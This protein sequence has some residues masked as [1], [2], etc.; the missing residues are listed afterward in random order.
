MVRLFAI[1]VFYKGLKPIQKKASYELSSFGYF[2]RS[3]VREFMA[4]TSDVLVERTSPGQRQ[5]VREQEYRCHV[6]VRSD[7][8]AC[9]AIADMDYPVRVAF[10]LM[11]KVLELYSSDFPR[12]SWEQPP[13]DLSYPPLDDFLKKYQDPKEADS[14]M[15]VQQDL[16]DTKIV[17]H[18]TLEALLE[19]G[20]KLDDLVS[21][22]DKLSSTSKAFYK[23]AKGGT[24][25]VLQ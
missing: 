23:E 10:T 2:Q 24:C 22:T 20:E 6:F 19:R 15:R 9:V 16:D 18:E 5:S 14:I 17:L 7:G 4:F 12:S 1:N 8:L 21:K 13:S 25:C 3:G 11:N